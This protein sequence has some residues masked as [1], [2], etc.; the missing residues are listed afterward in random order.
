MKT[1]LEKLGVGVRL[2]EDEAFVTGRES[3]SGGAVLDGHADH[4]VVM[5]LSVLACAAEGPV[6]ISGAEAV[7]KSYPGFFKDLAAIPSVFTSIKL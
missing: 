4:R 1:E 6:T 7:S 5:A 2:A 3:I